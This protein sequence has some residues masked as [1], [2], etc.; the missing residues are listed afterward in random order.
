MIMPKL[1]CPRGHVIDLSPVPTPG[2]FFY[3]DDEKLESLIALITSAVL[4]HD[5]SGGVVL[6]DA[7]SDTFA[8]EMRHFYRCPQCGALAFPDED[9]PESYVQAH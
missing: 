2:E 4:Q 3:G 5:A 6:E 9:P 1:M 7:I 8:G